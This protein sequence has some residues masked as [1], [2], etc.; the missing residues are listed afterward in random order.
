MSLIKFNDR[1][2]FPWTPSALT[3]FLDADDFFNDDF[4]VKDNLMPAI[5]VIEKDN[6]F[7][8][9]LAAP[10]FTKNDFDIT[11]DNNGL[12]LSAEKSIKKEE[13]EEG[14]IRK[15]FGYNSFKRSM[16]LPESIDLDKKV[17]ATYKDGILKF[18]LLKKEMAKVLPKKVIEV[19]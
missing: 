10:G 17:K 18:H 1:L 9:E 13:N 14:Y 7:D 5:N 6:E 8:F 11:I 16:R 19:I 4:F 15:E 2:R 3:N 12:H